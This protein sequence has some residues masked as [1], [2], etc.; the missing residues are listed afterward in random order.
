MYED[1]VVAWNHHEDLR[2]SRAPLADLARSRMRLDHL[3]DS[4]NA[5]RRAHAPNTREYHSVVMTAFCVRYR[6][7]VFLFSAD[8]RW[9]SD[10]PQYTCICGDPLGGPAELVTV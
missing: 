10:E 2:S 9:E 3:R 1:L 8:A 6:E 5:L 7:P 4:V